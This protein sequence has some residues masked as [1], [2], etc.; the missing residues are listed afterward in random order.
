MIKELDS[1]RVLD[2]QDV[3]SDHF[4]EGITIWKDRV[5]QLTW[6]SRVAF[7]YEKA[8]MKLIREIPYPREGW[9]ICHD[10]ELLI[11]SDGSNLLFFLDPETLETKKTVAVAFRGKDGTP[12]PLKYLNEL[13]YWNGKV[14]ANVWGK[15]FIVEI[16]PE[17]GWVV[18]LLKA[19]SIASRH[20]SENRDAVL[21]GIAVL[22]DRI[23]ITGKL[24]ASL[25]EVKIKKK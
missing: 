9:G 12:Q 25:Y 18:G 5:I 24:W 3:H 14:Y 19:S 21:N 15:N 1:G 20:L 2:Q 6:R 17:T 10:D 13:E 23:F 4:G 8:T 11:A 22:Q 16:D 7:E